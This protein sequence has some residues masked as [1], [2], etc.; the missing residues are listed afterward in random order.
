MT[1]DA[2][3]Y[4]E[5]SAFDQAVQR[6]ADHDG[7]VSTFQCR[8]CGSVGVGG[9]EMTCC[10]RQM[11]P[12]E[13]AEPAVTPGLADV[14]RDVFGMNETALAVCIELMREGPM[15]ATEVAEVID[16]DASYAKRLLN[17]L[18]DIHVVEEE[19][20]VLDGGGRI[21]KYR[22]APVPEVEAA[23]KSELVAWTVEALQ[24]VDEEMVAEKEAALAMAEGLVEDLAAGDD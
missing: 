2:P 12:F 6:E 20:D 21:C 7:G 15:T 18:R 1:S 13:T 16:C 10:G 5:R 11:V 17:H 8:E 22:H 24:V 3:R 14:I 23:W 9:E 19:I 4:H